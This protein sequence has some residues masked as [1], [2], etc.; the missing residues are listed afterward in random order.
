LVAKISSHS[1]RAPLGAWLRMVVARL[2]ANMRRA[3]RT[4]LPLDETSRWEV[5]AAALDPELAQVREACRKE[6]EL[7]FTQTIDGLSAREGSLLRLYYLEQMTQEAIA[8]LYKVNVRTVQR[9]IVAVRTKVL[10]ETQRI[11][12][13]RMSDTEVASVLRAAQSQF[14]LTLSQILRRA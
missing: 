2:A 14:Q 8:A 13:E 4:H 1:G 7:A 10:D 6:F 5:A 12:A 11:R 3:E 9:W